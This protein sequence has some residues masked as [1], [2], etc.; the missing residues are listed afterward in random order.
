MGFLFSSFFWGAVIILFG[1][2][3]ILNAVFNI[4]IPV[5]SIIIALIFIYIGLKILFGSFGIKASKNTVV[6]SSSDL[7]SANKNEEY[8]IIFGRGSIDL[9]EVE[10]DDE[11]LN[12]EVNVIF[13]KGDVLIDPNKPVIVKVSSVFSSAHLPDGNVAAI[14]NNSYVSPGYVKG[15]KYISVNTDVVFGELNIIEIKKVSK[16]KEF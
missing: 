16:E 10:L 15:K 3:I 9:S 5:F 6:F 8:N 7:K 4:K 2:S 12:Y 11:H 14:G 1:L 13:G